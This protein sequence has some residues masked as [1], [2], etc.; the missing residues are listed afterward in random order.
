MQI[1]INPNELDTIKSIRDMINWCANKFEQNGIFLGH[2]TD[3]A[4]DEALALVLHVIG[5]DYSIA[6]S[7][8]DS[9]ISDAEKKQ[10][11]EL[12]GLRIETRK[13][14]AYLTGLAYF[15]GL[16]FMVNEQVLVPRSPIA[17][18]IESAYFPW[19]EPANVQS[20]LDLCTGSGCIGIASAY[21]LPQAKVVL[22][23]I[24]ADAIEV[25]RKNIHKH[26]LDSRV[27]VIQSDIFDNIPAQKFDLIVSNPPYVS[28]AEYQEL[29]AEYLNEPKL[30]LTSGPDG[31]DL[32]ARIL[33]Q[34]AAFL[35]TSGIIIIEVGASAELLMQRYPQVPFNW[36][37]FEY[38]GDGVFT[39]S[40]QELE[41]YQ[42]AF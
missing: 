32:V 11:A 33:N 25:A 20:I 35:S 12:A 18:L 4:H 24:S 26:Q 3:N 27:S 28:E 16:E 19:V 9:E 39:L 42:H 13:P 14:L 23:D 5:K 10:A 34:A 22:S 29:P 7:Y 37:E 15:A 2:G 31:M 6:E 1:K 40:K 38:G 41:Q 17:E 21:A 8:L 30:G 36:I